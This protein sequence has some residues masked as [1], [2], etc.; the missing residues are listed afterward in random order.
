MS[1]SLQPEASSSSSPNFQPIFEK[2][3]QEYKRKTGKDLTTHSLAAE[4]KACDSPEAILTVLEGKVN[5]LN[6]SRSSDERLTKWLNPTVNILNA[7]SATLGEG[8]GSVFPP[9]KI[10]FSGIGILLVVS[11]L[12][13]HHM[14]R[15][16]AVSGR[17]AKDTVANRDVLVELFGGIESFFER[18]RIYTEVPP[19][20]AVT[21]LLVKNMAD[22][23]QILAIA[24]KGIK[25]KRP[26]TFL[27]KLVGMNDDIKDALQ[28]LRKLEQGELLTVIAQTLRE[29]SGLQD[30]TKETKAMIKEVTE[31]MDARDWKEMLLDL[32]GWLSPSDPST[33]YAIGLRDL[34]EETASWFLEG[35]IFQEWFSTGSLLWIHGKPGSGKSI[36]CSAIVQRLVSLCDDGRA[37]IGVFLF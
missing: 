35:R 16:N 28:R 34:H 4:I 25:E 9:T 31:K 3:L 13:I 36:L 11:F 18:L 15:D 24:T 27:K 5:E 30:D 14:G 20:L 8:F 10:I 7:L 33:N 2:A 12:S 1:S 22:I 17:P 32:K 26:A 21:N 23:L 19:P 37:S 6:Q 29:T